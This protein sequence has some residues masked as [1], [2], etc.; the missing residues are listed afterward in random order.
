MAN[1]SKLRDVTLKGWFFRFDGSGMRLVHFTEGSANRL[2]PGEA[3]KRVYEVPDPTEA[4]RAQV[5][6]DS[7]IVKRTPQQRLASMTAKLQGGESGQE[8]AARMMLDMLSGRNAGSIEGLTDEQVQTITGASWQGGDPIDGETVRRVAASYLGEAERKVAETAR[9]T[10][11]RRGRKARR[12]QE[13]LEA[14]ERRK[15]A[16]RKA[17]LEANHENT[18]TQF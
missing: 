9:D 4:M 17:A 14:S 16:R 10:T 1:S 12:E 7:P 13:K 8:A 15:Y 5:N 6:A 3:G 18:K 2:A 11:T